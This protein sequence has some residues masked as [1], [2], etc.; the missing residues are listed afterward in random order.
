MEQSNANEKKHLGTF[1]QT[2]NK[3][4]ISDP[5]YDYEKNDDIFKLNVLI[6]NVLPGKWYSYVMI[7][8]LTKRNAELIAINEKIKKNI[9]HNC[10]ISWTRYPENVWVD[11]G[12][13][14]IF[15]VKH[16]NDRNIV[17]D[18][19]NTKYLLSKKSTAVLPH[20]VFSLSGYGDGDYNL[21]V[22]MSDDKVVAVKIVFIDEQQREKYEA[23]FS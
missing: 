21:F 3:M 6:K 5:S 20:G 16:Y 4:I 22:S 12:R 18:T 2:S 14:G 19:S 1:D 8:N 13:A 15:D 10:Y 7:D 23:L 9:E 17:T 11:S